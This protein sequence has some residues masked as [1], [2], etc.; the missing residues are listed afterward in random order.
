MEIDKNKKSSFE[1]L[2]IL[3]AT[4]CISINF[5]FQRINYEQKIFHINNCM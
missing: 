1:F 3:S 5:L 4:G 2:L